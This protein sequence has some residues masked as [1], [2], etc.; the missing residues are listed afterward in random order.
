MYIP[1]KSDGIGKLM[2]NHANKDT[3]FGKTYERNV[4]NGKYSV[5]RSDMMDIVLKTPKSAFFEAAL[6]V[7]NSKEYKSCQVFIKQ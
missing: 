2:V 3:P 1:P 6:H 4:E 7:R 5:Q